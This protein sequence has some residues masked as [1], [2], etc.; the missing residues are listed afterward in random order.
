M[1]K[2]LPLYLQD[3]GYIERMQKKAD[4][5]KQKGVNLFHKAQKYVTVDPDTSEETYT[6]RGERLIKRANKNFK[7]QDNI[8]A[9]I[10]S[11]KTAKIGNQR[12][13]NLEKAGQIASA[14]A[15]GLG[16]GINAATSLAA[17]NM[18]IA[19]DSS[20]HGTQ[21]AGQ[22]L[23]A[24]G[25]YGT[26]AAS[27]LTGGAVLAEG[28]GIGTSQLSKSQAEAAGLN[29]GQRM[30]NNI[31]GI[32]AP[33]IG[34][35]LGKTISATQKTAETQAVSGAYAD[36]IG[37]IDA[38]SSMGGKRYVFG[39]D[40]I[41]N[42]ITEANRKNAILTEIGR[43]NTLRKQSDYGNDLATQNQRIYAG[44]SYAQSAIG[45]NGLKLASVDEIKKLLELR[46]ESE[47]VQSF[48]NGGVIGIDVNV[49]PE[50]KYHAH[51]NHLGEISEEFEDLTKKGI[52]VIA[53]AEGGEIEQVA[54]IEKMEIIF[55]LEVTKKLEELAKDGSEEAMI[56]AGKLV[57]YEIIENTQDNSGEVLGDE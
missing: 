44:T 2:E 16:T 12:A 33:G 6:K 18:N 8:Q 32:L 20:F 48:H 36:A 53:H 43:T 57:A 24:F 13:A 15:S 41:N 14:A 49:I 37:D 26:L 51:K 19:E 31:A 25:P 9:D 38:A 3:G 56:E 29:G 47:D 55:R 7:S 54:E 40:N 1:I 10:D 35:A 34:A 27:V 30:V 11:G 17:S 50:G 23:S 21:Q 22:M 52:P 45:K 39:K 5:K 28:L 42:L 4:H 46:K